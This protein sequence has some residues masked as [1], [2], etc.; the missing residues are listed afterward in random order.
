MLVNI[1][2]FFHVVIQVTH[3]FRFFYILLSFVRLTLTPSSSKNTLVILLCYT[4]LFSFVCLL[5]DLLHRCYFRFEH[6]CFLRLLDW[7]N[8]FL[9]SYEVS[10]LMNL[11]FAILLE[12]EG[13]CYSSSSRRTNQKLHLGT[14]YFLIS[15]SSESC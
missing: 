14:L 9:N 6:V 5:L 12:P 3:F 13:I 11:Y 1:I 8:I 4:V 7:Y 2:S 10:S 15:Y